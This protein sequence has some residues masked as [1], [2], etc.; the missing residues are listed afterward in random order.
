MNRI[1]VIGGGAAGM[2]AAGQAAANG[3]EV[4]LLEKMQRPGRKIAISGKGRCN[5]TNST[6]LPDF[7]NHFG[8]NGRFLRQAFQHFFNQ[9]LVHFFQEQGL[10]LITER[11]GRIFP[12]KGRAPDVVKILRQWLEDVSVSLRPDSAVEKLLLKD[13]KIEGVLCNGKPVY[14]KAVIRA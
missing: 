1:L 6:D 9:D 10:E 7:I 14:G 8:K 3:A 12:E 5:L 11:G 4:V 2:L 13:G